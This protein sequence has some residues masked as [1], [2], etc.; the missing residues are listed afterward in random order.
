MGL[1]MTNGIAIAL[2]LCIV[3]FFALDHFVLH[4]EAGVFVARKALDL[5]QTMAFWR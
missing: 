4:W 5:I 1:G 3:G 2:F